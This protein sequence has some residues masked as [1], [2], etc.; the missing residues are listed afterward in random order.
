V[1]NFDSGAYFPLNTFRLCDC[2]YS[3]CEGTVITSALT[4]YSYTSREADTLLL[5]VPGKP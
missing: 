3:S 2:P 4:V 5:I 1:I